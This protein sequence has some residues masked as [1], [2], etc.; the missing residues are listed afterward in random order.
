MWAEICL[1]RHFVSVA[2]CLG[3]CTPS[4]SSAQSLSEACVVSAQGF[5][6]CIRDEHF[7]HQ[8]RTLSPQAVLNGNVISRRA[9]VENW[10]V[11]Y[12]EPHLDLLQRLQACEEAKIALFY[13]YANE[14]PAV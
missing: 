9:L 7:L 14:S 4:T 10:D 3:A 6:V 1:V 5:K 8:N 11:L 13:N 2:F 12:K